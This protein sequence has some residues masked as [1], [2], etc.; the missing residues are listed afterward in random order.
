MKKKAILVVLLVAASVFATVAL[1]HGPRGR[2]GMEKRGLRDHG[3][4]G[5]RHGFGPLERLEKLRGELGLSDVQVEA[6]RAI[7]EEVRNANAASR[8]Q[9]R[10]GMGDVA[11]ILIANPDDLA[12]ARKA[13]QAR[14]AAMATIKDNALEGASRAL[15]VLTPGQ[16]EKLGAIVVERQSRR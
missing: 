5:E 11:S 15:K 2:A 16:R 6:I 4:M 1:A 8:D 10:D 13:M 14:E 9:L 7:R 12:G 3:M